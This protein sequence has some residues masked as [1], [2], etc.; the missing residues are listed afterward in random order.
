[1]IVF[2]SRENQYLFSQ[3]NESF[4]LYLSFHLFI[5]AQWLYSS[6]HPLSFCSVLS[7]H[8]S[9][10]FFHLH[11]L[12]ASICFLFCSFSFP[13]FLHLSAHMCGKN[14]ALGLHCLFHVKTSGDIKGLQRGLSLCI[15]PALTV[16]AQDASMH[17]ALHSVTARL[18]HQVGRGQCACTHWL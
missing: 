6:H 2:S 17:S 5:L 7:S 4:F 13:P 16:C 14:P 18:K 15:S 3:G 8:V 9:S 1:M 11:P 12:A 10:D